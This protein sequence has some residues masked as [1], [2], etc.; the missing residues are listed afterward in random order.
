MKIA[1]VFIGMLLMC[2][3]AFSATIYVPDHHTTIQT[4]IDAASIGDTIIVRPGTYNEIIEFRGKAITL[5]SEAG[6]ESTKIDGNMMGSVVKFIAGE[7]RDTIIEGFT[8]RNGIGTYNPP[9]NNYCG[10]GIRCHLASPTIIG[11]IIR[12]NSVLGGN[13]NGGGGGIY[14]WDSC[15]AIID[16]TICYNEASP[17]GGIAGSLGSLLIE[18]NHIHHN[19][20]IY[21]GGV[22][23]A[24]GS[25]EIRDNLIIDNTVRWGGGGIDCNGNVR[26]SIHDNLIM[27]NNSLWGGGLSFQFESTPIV[28]NN[29]VR[30]NRATGSDSKGGGVAVIW[31]AAPIFV[32]NTIVNNTVSSGSTYNGGGGVCTG[33]GGNPI[34]VNCILYGNSAPKGDEIWL[35]RYATG[36]PGSMSIYFSD[37]EGGQSAVLVDPGATLTWGPGMIDADPLFVDEAQDDFHLT[38]DSPCRN[39]GLNHARLPDMDFDGDTRVVDGRVD[40]GA[41]EFYFHLYHS[42]DVSPG[43]NLDLCIVGGPGMPVLLGHSTTLQNPPQST[44]WGDLY[45]TP[46]LR[47]SSTIGTIPANGVLTFPITVP[48]YWSPGD[49]KYFQALV[50][51]P[52]GPQTTLTNLDSLEVK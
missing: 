16:N 36:D 31:H 34:I 1:T 14:C 25:P 8:I 7:G 44:A 15:A 46:P 19:W 33:Y 24:Y 42:G 10:G 3:L 6:P 52:S 45:L 20:G 27:N 26:G 49:E 22:Q 13:G 32:N 21:G 40:I 37:V 29:V 18:G 5:R 30:D 47:W 43:S 38:W 11:N 50:G 12:D 4:A 39:A 23:Y 51:A 17:G 28:Y 41:D 9:Y 48:G 2:A 35:T